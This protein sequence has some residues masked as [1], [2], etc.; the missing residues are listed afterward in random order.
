MKA[1]FANTMN[2]ISGYPSP[3]FTEEQLKQIRGYAFLAENA[4]QLIAEQLRFIY[5]NNWFNL[6]VPEQLGGLEMDLPNAVR[7]Q[8]RLA[9]VDGSFGWT[10]TLC[11]GANW[12]A[13]FLDAALREEVFSAPSVCLSG[14][15]AA[16]G[17]AVAMG[18]GYIISGWWKY[19]TGAPHA[20]HFTAN[21][22]VGEQTDAQGNP[23]VSSFIFK[24]DEVTII[25]DWN[26]MGMK[27]TASQSFSVKDLYVSN[28]RQFLIDVAHAQL[29][30]AVFYFPFEQFAELTI[31]A[32]FAG[33][34]AHFIELCTDLFHERVK[35]KK[36]SAGQAC[37]VFECLG[38]SKTK[39]ETERNLLFD[40][41][42]RVWLKG[43]EAKQ[44]DAEDLQAVTNISQSLV[45]TARA[46]V[47]TL[48]PFCGMIAADASS[49]INRVWRDFNTASQHSLFTFG[50]K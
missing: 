16:T 25:N 13:G 7:L 11:A 6:F 47:N 48:Y 32:N 21:C 4:G 23:V 20:T 27:A 50:C 15:G 19:A 43:L 10:V 35:R 31:A 34:T 3:L 28:N 18:D 40:T 1:I 26:C 12:F 41:M 22:I 5:D 17:N 36:H 24:R 30:Q 33:M 38:R 44:W 39:F 9:Y 29:P 46:T 45:K 49:E 2:S 8:E 37:E 14:S 42:D